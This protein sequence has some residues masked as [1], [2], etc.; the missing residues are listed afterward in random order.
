MEIVSTVTREKLYNKNYDRDG[1]ELIKNTV[2]GDSK[3]Y[4]AKLL[5]SIKREEA[6]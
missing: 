1:F 6:R 3:K 5:V 2:N 4:I